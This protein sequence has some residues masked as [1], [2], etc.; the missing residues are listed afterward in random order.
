[1]L[2]QSGLQTSLNQKAFFEGNPLCLYGDLAYLLG[3]HLR[4][5]FRHRQ[6]TQ[7]ILDYNEAMSRVRTSV[8]WMFGNISNFFPWL[9]LKGK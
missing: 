5:P 9:I 6:P 1:M 7:E 2:Y 8:E 3:L 4:G